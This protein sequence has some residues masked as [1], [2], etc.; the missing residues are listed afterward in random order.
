MLTESAEAATLSE[1]EKRLNSQL[2]PTPPKRPKRGSVGVEQ[3]QSDRPPRRLPPIET[4]GTVDGK[5]D[6]KEEDDAGEP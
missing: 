2:S 1:E 5:K 4:A 6:K 3:A